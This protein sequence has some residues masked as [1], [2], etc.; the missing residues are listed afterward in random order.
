MLTTMLVED[1]ASFRKVVRN[2]LLSRFPSMKIIEASNGEEA[3][4]ELASNPADL[5][6]MDISMP[7]Q[8]GI[9]LTKEIKAD[10][11]SPAV[12][13]LSGYD[14]D[15]YRKAALESGAN[16]FIGK[17]SV[18]L[19]KKISTVVGCFHRRK[20]AGRLKPGCLLIL[21]K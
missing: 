17:D 3:F 5:I 14:L 8:N 18:G 7:G 6:L 20:E 12:I 21:S 11:Q 16:G 19:A 2:D 1:Q 10:N 4:K 15:A 9:M 13:M